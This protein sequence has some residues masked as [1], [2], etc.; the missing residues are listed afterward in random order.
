[1]SK[2]RS[3]AERGTEQRRALRGRIVAV[4]FVTVAVAVVG[5]LVAAGVS[6]TVG[7]SGESPSAPVAREVSALLSG[8]PQSGDTLGQASAP[9]TLQIFGDLQSADVRTFVVWLLPR[10]IDEWVRPD[11]V[12]LR[13]RSFSTASS[14]YPNE[15]LSQQTA[16]LA[17]GVQDRLWNFIETFY[18]EQGREH[19]RYATGAFLDGIA[20]RVS[21]LNLS[22]WED[23]RHDSQLAERVVEDNRAAR[24]VGFPDA[25]IFLIGRTDG[26]PAPWR[27]YRLYEEPGLKP[28]F[29]RRPQHP[30]SFLTSKALGVIIRDLHLARTRASHRYVAPTR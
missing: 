2:S 20:R 15:F 30:I 29:T 19:T 21:G 5:L 25:P 9:I 8:I 28:G 10:I 26:K 13:Y 16:A 12:K 11:V 4:G 22:V 17:A 3:V 14:P 1:M 18:R 7:S 27:G 24:A 23:D 6:H